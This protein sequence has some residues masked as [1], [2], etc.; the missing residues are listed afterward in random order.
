MRV[1]IATLGALRAT[2]TLLATTPNE[3][4]GVDLLAAHCK[5]QED[6]SRLLGRDWPGPF[7]PP[8]SYAELKAAHEARIDRRRAPPPLQVL[9][10]VLACTFCD[11]PQGDAVK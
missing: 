5:A 11:A 10:T 6:V 8:P 1:A 9:P 7:N 3:Q 4:I 2:S